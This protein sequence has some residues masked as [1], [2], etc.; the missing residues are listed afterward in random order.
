MI[1]CYFMAAKRFAEYNDFQRTGDDAARYR[2]SFAHYTSERLLVSIMFYASAA[3]LFFGAFIVR[4]RL[5]LILS[6]PLVAVFMAMYL[7]LAFRPDSPVENPEK[8]YREREPHD[9]ARR[10]RRGDDGAAARRPP[11]PRRRVLA[12]R[13]RPRRVGLTDRTPV[14]GGRRYGR[15]FAVGALL[16]ALVFAWMLTDGTFDPG[17]RVPFSGDFYDAQAHS[18]LEGELVDAGVGA[19]HRGVRARRELVHVLRSRAR[20]VAAPDRGVH[21]FARRSDGQ[22]LDAARVRG[23]DG[24]ARTDLLARA[25]LGAWRRARRPRRRAARRRDRVRR[26]AR[27]PRSCS[28]ASVRTCTTRRSCGASRSRSPPSPRSWRG[29]NSLDRACWSAAGVL[30]LLALLSRLAVGIG[31]AAALAL[32]AVAV[33]VARRLAPCARRDRRAWGSPPTDSDGAPVGCAGR[34]GRDPARGLRGA[35]TTRSSARSSACPT[36]TRRRTRSC[37]DGGRSWPPTGARS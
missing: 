2:K 12:E 18:M 37:P 22:R 23:G 6:F 25:A 5:E 7:H 14:E 10:V 16:A 34:G 36:T 17:H 3:M 19:R 9:R 35:S 31:P 24:R 8:L 13:P 21:R 28:S 27:G 1:G 20:A 30:T 4:Y 15:G 11:V 26:S 33:A 32:L 29:S